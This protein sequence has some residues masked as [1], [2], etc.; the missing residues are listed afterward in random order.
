MIWDF[1]LWGDGEGRGGGEGGETN[2]GMPSSV[3]LWELPTIITGSIPATDFFLLL[4]SLL[5]FFVRVNYQARQHSG[6]ML[7]CFIA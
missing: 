4:I 6:C 3:T 5:S 2:P 7:V 1:F